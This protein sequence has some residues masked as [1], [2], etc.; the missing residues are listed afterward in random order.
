M[1]AFNCKKS[2]VW[3][4]PPLKSH[5]ASQLPF[6]Q[7][8]GPT[9]PLLPSILNTHMCLNFQQ[10]E[11][12]IEILLALIHYLF[13]GGKVE[14]TLCARRWIRRYRY[15]V[16]NFIVATGQTCYGSKLLR[17]KVATGSKLLRVEVATYKAATLIKWVKV[18]N[19]QKKSWKIRKKMPI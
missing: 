19:R 6:F 7:A 16:A 13:C 1:C 12:N 11:D 10:A 9:L 3:N 5:A 14:V 18:A 2:L 8:V 17:V 4:G 15:K